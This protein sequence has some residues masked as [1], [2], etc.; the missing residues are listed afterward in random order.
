MVQRVSVVGQWN[1]KLTGAL[2]CTVSRSRF[3][4]KQHLELGKPLVFLLWCHSSLAKIP[5]ELQT[6]QAW[7]GSPGAHTACMACQGLACSAVPLGTFI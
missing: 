5:T 1:G 4:F 7:H 6:L 3:A 2:P